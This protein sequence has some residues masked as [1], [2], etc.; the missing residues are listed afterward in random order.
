PSCPRL[1]SAMPR[2]GLA[3][4]AIARGRLSPAEAGPA[5][6]FLRRLIRRPFPGKS[7]PALALVA[8]AAAAHFG[9]FR[10]PFLL[11]DRGAVLRNASIRSLATAWSPP[12]GG[13]TVSGR[14]VA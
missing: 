7:W 9:S 1:S 6:R 12:S 13:E 3:R 2:S 14:P 11:D 10:C 4:P 8:L 5:W